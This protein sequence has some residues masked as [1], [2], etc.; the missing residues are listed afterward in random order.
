VIGDA[1]PRQLALQSRAVPAPARG[2]HRDGSGCGREVHAFEL[3]RAKAGRAC[4][5]LTIEQPRT[6]AADSG[7]LLDTVT[8]GV[9]MS[10]DH[11][12]DFQGINAFSSRGAGY[13]VARKCLE[14]Q[15]AAELRDPSLR[16]ENRVVLHEDARPWLVGALGEIEVGRVLAQLGP[17]WFVRHSVPI[18]SGTTDVD[19]L[20][21]GPAGV[22]AINTKHHRGASVWVG[23]YVVRVGDRNEKYF[24]PSRGEGLNVARRLA[25]HVDFVVPVHPV[26]AVLNAHSFVDRRAVDAREVTVVEAKDLVRWLEQ[27]PDQLTETQVSLLTLAAEEPNTWHIDPR[28]ADTLR[29]MPRFERLVE[30]T[31]AQLVPTPPRVTRPMPQRYGSRRPAYSRPS[32]P[33]GSGK[34]QTSDLGRL[35]LAIII[36]VIGFFVLRALAG[37]PCTAASTIGCVAPYLYAGVKPLFELAIGLLLLIGVVA[38]LVTFARAADRKR[39]GL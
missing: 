18:G 27:Q 24:G 4:R 31:G 34:R 19:H 16:T 32:R 3:M 2:E 14:V 1:R 20:V 17:S 37:Q 12:V 33:A 29:V 9:S 7:A 11:T 25:S 36:V 38:T 28:A 6:G 13:A 22:F 23:D 39:R 35:W 8:L 30:Q 10:S 21:I 5:D 26:I 15:G